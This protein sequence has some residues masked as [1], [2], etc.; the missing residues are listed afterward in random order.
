[1]N[2]HTWLIVRF[3]VTGAL[4]AWLFRDR[5]VAAQ[6]AALPL[7]SRTGWLAL[8]WLAAGIGEMV[9]LLRFWCCLHLAG[10]PLPLR[11]TAALHFTGLFTSLFL[12]GMAGGDAIKVA[13]LAVHF[14]QRKLAG[15][16]AVLMDRLSG[17]VVI[18]AWTA[19]M[20]W[21]RADWFAQSHIA[22][23][24]LKAVLLTA[25][26]MAAALVVWFLLSRT[27]LMRR[28]LR[29]F[30]FRERI[31]RCETGF[32]AFVADWSRTLVVF[33]TSIAGFAAY[34]AIFQCTALAYAAPLVWRDTFSVM[35][36]LDLIIMLPVTVA[37]VGLRE[38]AFRSIFAPLCGLTSAQGVIV[39]LAGFLIA[40][41]WSLLG[42]PVFLSVRRAL[43][44]TR[45]ANA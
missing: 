45:D 26:P 33:L 31:I 22:A 25:V 30:P 32:D 16:L 28:R 14:P 4:L 43:Q 10:I 6:L 42:A 19:W 15:L 12:P 38:Q 37:G 2:R 3:L 9:G 24:A 36:L 7:P 34:F 41:T 1:M 5:T 11:H 40:S 44:T 39:S 21:Y 17:F 8:A 29:R 20:A 18:T 13:L 35:P 23:A 27:G